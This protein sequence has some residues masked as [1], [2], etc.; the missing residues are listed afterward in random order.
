V[1]GGHPLGRL[2]SGTPDTVGP[3]TRRQIQGFYHRRYEAP[4]LVIA[5]AGS[6]DHAA[7]VKHVREAFGRSGRASFAEDAIAEPAPRRAGAAAPAHKPRLAVRD[8]DTEQAHVVLG[9]RA[10][11]R[12]DERRFALGVLNN[13]LGGGMSS[14]LFQ[15]IREKRGLAYSVYSF[16]SQYAG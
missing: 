10:I 9:G 7:V 15:E 1:Y 4:R 8:K 3:M 6:L 14:R 13:L 16:T 2:I 12:D 11:A 5:A